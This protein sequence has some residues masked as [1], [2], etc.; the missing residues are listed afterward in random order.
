[1]KFL[2]VLALLIGAVIAGLAYLP[3]ETTG[4]IGTKAAVVAVRGCRGAKRF[5]EQFQAK[6]AEAK[7]PEESAPP[8][9]PAPTE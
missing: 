8:P 7:E 5:V 6:V 3:P 9:A 2:I 4:K 1:M